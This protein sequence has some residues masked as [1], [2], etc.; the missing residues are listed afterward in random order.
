MKLS[1][2]VLRIVKAI[3]LFA[4]AGLFSF[5]GAVSL[6]AALPGIEVPGHVPSWPLALALLALGFLAYRR[7]RALLTTHVSI[8]GQQT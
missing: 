5:V 6:V 8:E 7:A 4:V 1:E 2:L 3:A